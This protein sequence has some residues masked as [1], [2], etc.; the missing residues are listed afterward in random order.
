MVL[1]EKETLIYRGNRHDRRDPRS[2][3]C[4]F[5]CQFESQDLDRMKIPL[6]AFSGETRHSSTSSSSSKRSEDSTR[7]SSCN[8][9]AQHV[10]FGSTTASSPS[11]EVST[12]S[13]LFRPAAQCAE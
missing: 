2:G 6:L 10:H 12:S 8:H 1:T 3:S 7:S 5:L 13:E 11:S 9:A 4:M